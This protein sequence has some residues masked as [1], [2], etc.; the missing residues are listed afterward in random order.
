ML[1]HLFFFLLVPCTVTFTGPTNYPTGVGSI[2]TSVTLA[3]VDGDGD[4]DAIVSNKG[5]NDVGVLLGNGDGTF[6]AQ[7]TYGLLAAS[8]PASV[9]TADVDDD[10]DLDIIV[11]NTGTN[12]IGILINNP[13]GTFPANQGPRVGFFAGS[14]PASVTTADV[15]GD[16]KADI[17]VA[18]KNT[19]N[20]GVLLNSGTGT[21]PAAP[22]TYGLLANSAPT[23]VKTADA[24]GDGK[25]DIIVAN[26]G[27]NNFGVILGNGDG[28]FAATQLTYATGT[29]TVPVSVVAGDID[30]DGDNDVLV[31]DS[32]TNQIGVFL[33]VCSK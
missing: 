6:A 29:G 13:T 10:G 9:T 27:T 19:N 26:S 12:D 5:T 7:K 17:I 2:P 11:A 30:R 33:A 24:N 25:L 16:G 20:V 31:A 4:L 21:F 28:T 22:V 8:A 3:D 1:H 23:S 32:G 18:Y 15:N 14:A